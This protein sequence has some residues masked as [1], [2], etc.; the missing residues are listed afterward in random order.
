MISNKTRMDY[1]LAT[2]GGRLT[3]YGQILQKLQILV[4]V[5]MKHN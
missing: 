5:T 2:G 3:N 1:V 4:V